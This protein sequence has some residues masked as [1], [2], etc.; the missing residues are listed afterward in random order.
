MNTETTARPE[1]DPRHKQGGATPAAADKKAQKAQKAH[2]EDVL[3]EA[4]DESFPASDPIA[5]TISKAPK[6]TP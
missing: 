3:D 2:A 6:K 1:A 4:L 5:V